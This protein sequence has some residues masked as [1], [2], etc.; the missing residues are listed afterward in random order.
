MQIVHT[1][2]VDAFQKLKHLSHLLLGQVLLSARERNGQT[3]VS[4]NYTDGNTC[5]PFVFMI[6]NCVFRY[7][8]AGSSMQNML[9][10]DIIMCVPEKNEPR[11]EYGRK[12]LEKTVPKSVKTKSMPRK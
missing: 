5:C 12:V 4:R 2:I 9:N 10:Y 8:F 7:W 3:I 1:M 6:I 11:L